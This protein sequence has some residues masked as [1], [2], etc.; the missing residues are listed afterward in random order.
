MP[1]IGVH[2]VRCE[3]A[4]VTANGMPVVGRSGADIVL[5]LDLLASV[6]NLL[7]ERYLALRRPAYSNL[8]YHC[9]PGAIRFRLFELL[10]RHRLGEA[11]G[12]P[13]PAWDEDLS[14]HLLEHIACMARRSASQAENRAESHVWP[15]QPGRSFAIT[16]DVDT[17]RAQRFIPAMRKA[18][19][20]CPAHWFLVGGGY[21]L[22]RGLIREL[23][24]SGD[25]ICLHGVSHQESLAF[26]PLGEIRK[27]LDSVREFCEEYRIRGFRAPNF[28]VS[29]ALFRELGGRFSYD[30]SVPDTD[31]CAIGALKRGCCCVRPFWQVPEPETSPSVR[32]TTALIEFPA[33]LPPEDKLLALGFAPREIGERWLRKARRVWELGGIA[34]LVLHASPHLYTAEL[35]A[36]VEETVSTLRSEGTAVRLGEIASSTGGEYNRVP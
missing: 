2:E 7:G 5:G 16:L 17:A 26:L 8:P 6:A 22:D 23:R 35:L 36:V 9:V 33:N 27:R 1:L 34:T 29:E 25:E 14:V 3:Q 32:N 20:E 21:R 13:F 11:E 24:D 15:P 10:V 4:L 12:V 30:S 28:L 19:G 18:L 31:I